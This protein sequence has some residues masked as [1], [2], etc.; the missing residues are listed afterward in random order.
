MKYYVP[1]HLLESRIKIAVIG[2]GGTGSELVDGL[3]RID[4]GL[5]ALGHKEGIHVTAFD[6]DKVAPHNIG[7][8]RYSE[9]DIGNLKAISLVHRINMF[10]GSDWKS[11]PYFFKAK[12]ELIE[13]FDIVIG[14]VDKAKFRAQMGKIGKKRAEGKSPVL[15]LDYGNSKDTG[16]VILGHLIKGRKEKFWLPN[17]YD[18]YPSLDNAELDNDDTPRC[19]LAEALM[20]DNGQDL[21]IN[22]TLADFGLNIL[23][24]LLTKGSLDNHG[25]F[26]D[27]RT[28]KSNPLAI[29][30]VTWEFFGLKD[31]AA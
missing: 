10:H 8:Q 2:V 30:P 3:V 24:Q 23:W 31:K 11:I 16:Q 19:S 13:E 27:V 28:L 18:L 26:I 25:A 21:F 17:V 6:A 15:W 14:C 20:G 22:R 4:F 1:Q 12:K 29:D 7:R 5:K 9:A